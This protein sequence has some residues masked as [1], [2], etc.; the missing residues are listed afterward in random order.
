MFLLV[1]ILGIWFNNP[2]KCEKVGEK[3]TR[4]QL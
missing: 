2:E 4:Y 1:E 3:I